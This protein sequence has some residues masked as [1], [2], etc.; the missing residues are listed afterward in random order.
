[1]PNNDDLEKELKEAKD[2]IAKLEQDIKDL[3]EDK[4][5]SENK[6]F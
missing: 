5:N 6:N 2:K 3:T 1:M 4:T